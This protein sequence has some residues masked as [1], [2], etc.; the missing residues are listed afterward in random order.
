M[1]EPTFDDA[2]G[3]VERLEPAREASGRTSAEL[4]TTI[5]IGS[6]GC[7]GTRRGRP[8]DT[9]VRWE[10]A[11]HFQSGSRCAIQSGAG[12]ARRPI[13]AE[14][15]G[16]R[17]GRDR[18]GLPRLE[19]GRRSHQRDGSARRST[20]TVSESAGTGHGL[21]HR[22]HE[23]CKRNDQ[24]RRAGGAHAEPIAAGVAGPSVA[25]TAAPAANACTVF[26]VTAGSILPAPAEG[27]AHDPRRS[28]RPRRT[29]PPR[30]GINA[31]R[32]RSPNT[33]RRRASSKARCMGRRVG[34]KAIEESQR[35]FF[36]SFPDATLTVRSDP[37]RSTVRRRL[38]P[39]TRPPTTTPHHYTWAWQT[40]QFR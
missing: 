23:S 10:A 1:A 21:L 5:L 9:V 26:L 6:I 30:R 14:R 15:R 24:R 39:S 16:V 3:V 18:G 25:R 13:R 38:A 36:T 40:R 20:G 31:I 27:G 4:P 12:T 29:A 35:A 22:F 37:D 32:R 19:H 11:L 28:C 7:A 8:W 34:R 17:A 33:I 2:L